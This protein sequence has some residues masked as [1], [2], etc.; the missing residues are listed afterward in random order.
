MGEQRIH[1]V[2]I[3]EIRLIH[4]HALQLVFAA[5][6][7]SDD[8]AAQHARNLLNRHPGYEGAEVWCDMRYVR[9]V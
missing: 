8:E 2:R 5:A 4:P 6:K 7:S 1:T 9:A 3:Y